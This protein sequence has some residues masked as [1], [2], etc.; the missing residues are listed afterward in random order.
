MRLTRSLQILLPAYFNM[1]W[2]VAC[3]LAWP[4]ISKP[5]AT[6]Q[7]LGAVI[8]IAAIAPLSIIFALLT[9]GS[10]RR[11]RWD[12]WAYLVLLVS[13]DAMVIQD[14]LFQSTYQIFFGAV[15]LVLLVASLIGLI[16]FGPWAMKKATVTASQQPRV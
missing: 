16:R 6:G 2:V 4:T 3:A 14:R 11:W 15:G 9:Y 5:L 10:M 13:F 7:R 12:L 1:G 8:I